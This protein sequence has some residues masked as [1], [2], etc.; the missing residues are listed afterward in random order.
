MTKP[1]LNHARNTLVLFAT[2]LFI[3]LLG[4]T[5]IRTYAKSMNVDPTPTPE[6]T[7]SSAPATTLQTNP[8]ED[9][10]C[11]DCHGNPALTGLTMDGETISLYIQPAAHQE[12]FHSREGGGCNK[13]CHQAQATYPHETSTAESCAVCHWQ[14]SGQAPVDGKLVFKLPYVDAR[15]ITLEVNTS[16]KKCHVEIFESTTDSAHTRI[17]LEGNRY[18]PLCSDCHSGHDISLVTRQGVSDVCKKCH[19]A[20]YTTYKGSVHGAALEADSNPDVPT[21]AG[22]HGSHLVSGPGTTDFR[23]ATVKICGDCHSDKTIMDKYGISTD[24]LS[25]YMD[26]A[27]GLTDF[28]RKTNL[29]NITRATCFDCHGKHNILSPDNPSSKVYP[30]NLQ[31]TCQQCHDDAN[32]RFPQSWLSHKKIDSGANPGLSWTNQISLFI[33]V[34]AAVIILALIILDARRR[35]ALKVKAGRN[36]GK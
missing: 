22:C 35:I 3:L 6:I 33:V 2:G 12:S 18:A 9:G 26:D 27:H 15:A 1:T 8:H 24:V 28:F 29:E 31:S 23:T 17:M 21:C 4:A 14:V 10:E 30:E 20:E 16:C 19:L 5:S 34:A 11:L 36:N 13:F 32:I 25:T 7:Q